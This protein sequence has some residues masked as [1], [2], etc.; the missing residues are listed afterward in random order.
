MEISAEA[1]IQIQAVV[2][3]PG[4]AGY[5]RC[6]GAWLALNGAQRIFGCGIEPLKLE[7]RKQAALLRRVN[8]GKDYGLRLFLIDGLRCGKLTAIAGLD[9]PVK[10]ALHDGGLHLVVGGDEPLGQCSI[11]GRP[12][13]NV[14]ADAQ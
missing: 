3:P 5:R 1:V 11:V 4:A 2:H 13:C 9:E 6:A 14:G 7:A 8:E 12:G 10:V